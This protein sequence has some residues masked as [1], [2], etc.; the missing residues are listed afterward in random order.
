MP[1]TTSIGLLLAIILGVYFFTVSVYVLREYERGVVFR[2]GRLMP[3]KGP[4]FIMVIPIID[5]LIKVSLRTVTI[6]VPTQDAVTKDNVSVQVSAVVYFRVVNPGLS[7]TEIEDFQYATSQISQTTLRSVLGQS[8]LDEILA[9]RDELNTTLEHIIDQQTEPWGVK[10]TH[11][12][13]KNLDLP[14]TM[15]RAI[16]RQAEAERERRAKIIHAE[17]EHQA[18]EKLADAASIIRTEPIALQLRYLQTMVEVATESKATV[19]APIPLPL[20]LFKP[21]L[22]VIAKK[23]A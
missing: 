2:L 9:K 21:F 8:H 20:D 3:V 23:G 6:E 16:A 13:V 10:V 14:E 17:G 5:K 12:E 18:A 7:V 1:Q 11:V 22:D 4:G 15:Q 19:L